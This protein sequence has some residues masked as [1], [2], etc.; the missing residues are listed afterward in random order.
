MSSSRF[1]ELLS[2]SEYKGQDTAPK[3]GK[4]SVTGHAS[5]HVLSLIPAVT[6]RFPFP[7]SLSL[8]SSSGLSLLCHSWSFP[9]SSVVLLAVSITD[10]L[11]FLFFILLFLPFLSPFSVSIV[12]SSPLPTKAPCPKELFPINSWLLCT[13]Q[14]RKA[15]GP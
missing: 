2:R 8:F 13:R 10:Y 7:G 15:G 14:S 11:P 3:T 5:D 6:H 4:D 12:P 1:S 9:T